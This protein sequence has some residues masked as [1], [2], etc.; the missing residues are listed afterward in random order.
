MWVE[1]KKAKAGL[2]Y[3]KG[4]KVN[5]ADDVAKGLMEDG[6][7]VPVDAKPAES[8][9]PIDL[10]GRA[11]LIKE[12]LLTKSQVLKAEKT[13]TDIPGIGSVTALQ[14]VESLKKGE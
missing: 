13:L 11:S 4:D 3:F 7:V 12:G 2:S 1:F 9:L 10:P 5:L 14:I 6:F 8:D